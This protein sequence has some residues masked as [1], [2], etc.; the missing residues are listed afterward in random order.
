MN[1]RPLQ[2]FFAWSYKHSRTAVGVAPVLENK[3]KTNNQFPYWD[4]LLLN[5]R[6]EDMR[7]TGSFNQKS[8][9]PT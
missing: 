1:I 8:F 4:W 7:S 2:Q 9:S 5:L 6:C 3:C